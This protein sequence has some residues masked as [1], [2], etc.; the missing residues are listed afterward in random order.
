MNCPYWDKRLIEGYIYGSR[1]P[2]VWMQKDSKPFLGL[3][4]NEAETLEDRDNKSLFSVPRVK[5]YKCSEC[6]K[7][8][9]NLE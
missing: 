6:K 3:F 7:L 2:L 8:I 4:P 5:A 1:V 9:V